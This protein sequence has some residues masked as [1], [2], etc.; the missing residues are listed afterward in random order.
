[1]MILYVTNFYFH[2]IRVHLLF[3]L[4]LCFLLLYMIMLQSV[5][6]HVSLINPILANKC[7]QRGTIMQQYVG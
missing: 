2:V 4:K 7:L 5:C 1:M 3:C 6:E